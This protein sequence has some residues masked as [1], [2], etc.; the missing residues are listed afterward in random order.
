MSS[1]RAGSPSSAVDIGAAAIASSY[2][3]AKAVAATAAHAFFLPSVEVQVL[4]NTWEQVR[5]GAGELAG[6]WR[7]WGLET[8]EG[9]ASEAR[10]EP[11]AYERSAWDACR[12]FL[13]APCL[14]PTRRRRAT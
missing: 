3:R 5:A 13:P 14:Q 7:D 8:R 10:R 2:A 4:A 1:C 11:W 6:V 12:Q 9:G